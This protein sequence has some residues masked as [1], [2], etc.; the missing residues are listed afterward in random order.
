MVDC[1]FCRIAA[2]EVPAA[3]L[4]ETET[5]VSFLDIAPVNPGHCLVV[6]KRHAATL[7]DLN[8]EELTDCVLAARQLARAVME[9]TGSPG[10]N[11][12][13]NNDRC[14]GQVVPHVHFHVI[15]R[16]PDD[17]FNF[18]WRQ[19]RYDEGELERMRNAISALLT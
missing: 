9:V 3:K 12:L 19:R 7:L 17:G 11:L 14:A 15:P 16:S 18:G 13:Q 2:G 1:V 5:V 10:L 4:I 6:P 8:D